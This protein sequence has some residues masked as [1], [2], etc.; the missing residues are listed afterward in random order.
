MKKAILFSIVLFAFAIKAN[1]Q[2]TLEH[3][4]NSAGS[5]VAFPNYQQLYIVKL[6]VDGEKYVFV[7]RANKQ[8]KFYNLNHTLWKTISYTGTIDFVS[9]PES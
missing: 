2:I 6:E 8:V 4:Y 5:L 3:T 1:A 9:S 7:D